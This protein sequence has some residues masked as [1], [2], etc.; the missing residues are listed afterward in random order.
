[1]SAVARV[2]VSGFDVTIEPLTL[3]TTDITLEVVDP[4]NETASTSFS[5]TVENL[6]PRVAMTLPNVNMN[7]VDPVVVD[8]SAVFV[9][10]DADAMVITAESGD[11]NL[12]TTSVS[13]TTLTLDGM[14]LGTTTV[15]VTATDANAGTIS[16]PPLMSPS[17]TSIRWSRPRS[18]N[19]SCR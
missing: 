4:Y 18:L 8:V 6:A 15:T 10:D 12:V 16:T 11:T 3:G 2:S 7:R 13:G 5:V 9:D 19:S 17:I 1:M 14:N